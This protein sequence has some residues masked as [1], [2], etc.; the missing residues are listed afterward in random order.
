MKGVGLG[1]GEGDGGP[2]EVPHPSVRYIIMLYVQVGFSST[3]ITVPSGWL[4]SG[5]A[6]VI[7]DERYTKNQYI[8]RRILVRTEKFAPSLSISIHL[9]PS[10]PVSIHLYPSLS[11]NDSN[12]ISGKYI[13][14][15]KERDIDSTITGWTIFPPS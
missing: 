15:Q 6:T 11:R 13:Y 5:H 4:A 14:R 8:V 9:Y 2:K 1:V 12:Q 7:T 3:S 10:L